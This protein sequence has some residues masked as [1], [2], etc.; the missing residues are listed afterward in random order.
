MNLCTDED[1]RLID[2]WHIDIV[3]L[4]ST[5]NNIKWSWLSV[6]SQCYHCYAAKSYFQISHIVHSR[7]SRTKN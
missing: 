5:I 7:T 2:I 4:L 3:G 6:H 1:V